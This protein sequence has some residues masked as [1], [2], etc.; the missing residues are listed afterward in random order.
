MQRRD[1]ADGPYTHWTFTFNRTHTEWLQRR[2]DEGYT[3]AK[4]IRAVLQEYIDKHG[5]KV[6]MG[7]RQD[8]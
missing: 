2:V 7:E 8:G 1:R 6:V 5:E 3:M 4:V